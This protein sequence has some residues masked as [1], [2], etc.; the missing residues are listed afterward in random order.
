MS[1]ALHR[2][3]VRVLV[4]QSQVQLARS[5]FGA[6]REHVLF[7]GQSK[8]PSSARS[9]NIKVAV[10]LREPAWPSTKRALR[11]LFVEAATSAL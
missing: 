1:A 8:H 9:F 7:V 4:G 11:A 6:R 10:G 5:M 2:N 3:A